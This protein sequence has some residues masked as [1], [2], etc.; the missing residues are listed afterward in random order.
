MDYSNQYI[1]TKVEIGKE[2]SCMTTFVYAKCT[3][4]ERQEL[5]NDLITFSESYDGAWLIGGDFNVIS[6]TRE[7]LGGVGWDFILWMNLTP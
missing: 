6:K 7:K 5:W 4:S 1:T 2:F 3:R